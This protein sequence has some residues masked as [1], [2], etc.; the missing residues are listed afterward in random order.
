[1]RAAGLV[2]AG[3]P[4]RPAEPVERGKHR[5]IID[6]A[7]IG[8][9]A[10]RNR[11]DLHMADQRQVLLEAGD[12][13]AADDLHMVEIVLDFHIGLADLGDDVGGLL[14][15]AE[16]IIRP[17]A[18]V[19]RLDQQGDFLVRGQ[20]GCARQV[21]DEGALGGGP[22]LGRNHAGHAVDRG[23]A[24]SDGVIERL[25]E[26]DLPVALAARHR[27][28]SGIAGPS[29]DECVDAELRQPVLVDLGFQRG[30]RVIVGR[31]QLDGLEASRCRRA[32]TLE[33]RPLGEQISEIGGKARHCLPQ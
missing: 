6:L 27:R 31:L 29:A 7:L 30:R 15:A 33:Q 11:G 10:R 25:L 18:R 20:V 14:D 28:Q 26:H 1:M 8:L 21:A 12:E 32:E 22:L 4:A 17:V 5:R 9:G 23:A 2:F 16:K 24:D 19:D 3:G 13:I